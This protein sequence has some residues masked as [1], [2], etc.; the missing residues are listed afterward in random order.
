MARDEGLA[1]GLIH[2]AP[3]RSLVKRTYDDVFGPCGGRLQMHGAPEDVK[4]PYFLS[5]LVVTTLDS[6][7]WNLYRVPVAESLKIQRGASMGHYYPALLAIF[8]SLV[9]FDEGH[10]YL[11]EEPSHGDP[12]STGASAALAAIA[13]LAWAGAPVLVETATA[14]PG[15]L[16]K[17]R[18]VVG[19]TRGRVSI[20][21]LK[22]PR[23]SSCCPYLDKLVI[24]AGALDIVVDPDWESSHLVPWE[25]RIKKSWRD[26]LDDIVDDASSGPVLVITNTV[27]EAVEL[28]RKLEGMAPRT[29]LVHGRLSGK[30][31]SKAE[32]EIRIVEDKGGVVVATQVAEAGVDVNAMAVYTA[33]APLES[34]VQRAGRA[35]RR[36]RILESCHEDGGRMVIVEEGSPGPYN[37]EDI[38]EA[39]KLV[40]N[41]ASRSPSY[42]D[43]RAPCNRGS[44][45]GYGSM[46]A[47]QRTDSYGRDVGGLVES[48]LERYLKSDARPWALLEIMDRSGLCGLARDSVM[49]EVDVGGSTV[50]ASLHWALSKAEEALEFRSGVPVLVVEWRGKGGMQSVE[51][52]A[53]RLW[54]AW[55][56][57]RK[58]KDERVYGCRRLIEDMTRDALDA[59]KGQGV[60]FAVYNVRLKAR[61]GAYE[62]GLGLLV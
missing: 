33:A 1:G 44:T 41:I 14:R 55:K 2:V 35:C 60:E 27:G 42:I 36:G 54:K 15:M 32:D 45:T 34:L 13:G 47:M 51:V 18:S 39:L 30:D 50:P 8:T 20:K 62:P 19:T 49:V 25:T 48:L 7:L 46:L 37:R 22:A 38:Q 10:M 5:S 40:S 52:G 59:L 3:L 21:A 11:W 28:Y 29:V 61:D 26:V 23:G 17:L 58:M 4:S 12:G 31:R 24:E 43:W 9:V 57:L 56:S 6:F 16:A 53:Y